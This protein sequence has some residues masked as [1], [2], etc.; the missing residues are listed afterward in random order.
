MI[1]K[2]AAASALILLLITG[3]SYAGELELN[4]ESAVLISADTG[5]LLYEL[6]KDTSLAPASVTKIMTLLIITEELEAGNISYDDVVTASERAKSMGGS[7][8]FLDAGE[9]MSVRDLMKGIA[10]A[11]AN[12]AC[13]AMAEFISGSEEAFVERMN[14]RAE[15]L[16]MDNTHFVNTNGLDAEG[17]EMSAYDIAKMSRELLSHKDILSFTTIWTDSLRDGKFDLANT[18]KLIR[19][20]EGATGL[21][22]GSTSG[23]GCC[24]S[25]SAERNGMS[26]IAVVMKAPDSAARFSAARTLLDYGFNNF[27]RECYEDLTSP[28]GSVGVSKGK[29]E[30]VFAVLSKP[31]CGISR[32][33][34]ETELVTEL[35]EK[36]KAPVQ[37]GAVIG[38]ARLM[39]EGK[40]I[41]ECELIAKDG[42]E[43]MSVAEAF[44]WAVK[45]LLRMN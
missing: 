17:H 40:V 21:K 29:E 31:L 45:L 3:A 32:K 43:K 5:E 12:D 10:V 1:K 13:V 9:Q 33:N 23:A 15:E 44:F 24:I 30:G 18:N 8:I 22:T 39:C 36:K 25:A 27:K 41:D 37:K 20:Y 38:R 26:L 7:T 11:S 28:L 35:A 16:G 4:C 19:F 6:N 34:A 2:I 42:V 14:K